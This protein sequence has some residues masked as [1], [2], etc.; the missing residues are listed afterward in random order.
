MAEGTQC[1][2]APGWEE[3]L[4]GFFPTA[5]TTLPAFA[6]GACQGRPLRRRLGHAGCTIKPEESRYGLDDEKV[7]R[8]LTQIAGPGSYLDDQGSCRE[9][10]SQ[11]D[12]T[13]TYGGDWQWFELGEPSSPQ[14]YP[15]VHAI[16]GARIQARYSS[17][18]GKT[19][20][21]FE[22]FWDSQINEACRAEYPE[23]GPGFCLPNSIRSGQRSIYSE[24]SC[25]SRLALALPN[26][27]E[28][29]ALVRYTGLPEQYFEIE[30]YQGRLFRLDG[31]ICVE[32]LSPLRKFRYGSQ[33]EPA[34]VFGPMT[35]RLAEA[36]L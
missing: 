19:P 6:G 11:A 14:R 20:L 17:F 18:D 10:E 29:P 13:P 2:L 33:V 27:S 3:C 16:R 32:D 28:P 24:S 5:A 22:N 8:S 9:W 35:N 1:L 7:I 30:Q 23:E 21:L 31:G 4:P 25:S 34:E 36:Q 12:T 15:I 26:E